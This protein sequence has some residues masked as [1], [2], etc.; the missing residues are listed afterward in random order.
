MSKL[1]IEKVENEVNEEIRNRFAFDNNLLLVV[2]FNGQS[3]NAKH[4][5][6]DDIQKG[7]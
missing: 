4:K 6:S 3:M 1:F 2:K 7:D 5:I